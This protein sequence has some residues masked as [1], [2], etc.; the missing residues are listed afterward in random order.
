[1]HE[2]FNNKTIGGGGTCFR[3]IENTLQ[4]E[5][6]AGRAK[7]TT[8]LIVVSDGY[9]TPYKPQNPKNWTWLLTT[10]GCRNYINPQSK[11]YDLTGFE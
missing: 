2:I 11:I 9:G 5:I 3:C 8:Q 4:A 6:A 1:M 10:G 7:K